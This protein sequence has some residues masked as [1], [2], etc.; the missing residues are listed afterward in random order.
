[1]TGVGRSNDVCVAVHGDLLSDF[2]ILD[3]GGAS[4][5]LVGYGESTVLS[6]CHDKGR[7]DIADFVGR[8]HDNV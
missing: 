4:L 8:V 1:M 2:T 5:G 6:A 3:N 7:V